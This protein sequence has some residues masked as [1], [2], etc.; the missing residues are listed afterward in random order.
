MH[1][2][3][4]FVEKEKKKQASN[5]FFCTSFGQSKRTPVKPVEN[6]S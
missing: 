1:V 3:N 4:V 6:S 2:K 5:L